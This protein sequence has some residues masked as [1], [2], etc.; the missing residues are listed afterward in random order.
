MPVLQ[1][2]RGCAAVAG[3]LANL[4]TASGHPLKEADTCVVKFLDGDGAL[5]GDM[6]DLPDPFV[7]EEHLPALLEGLD[8]EADAGFVEPPAAHTWLPDLASAHVGQPYN[9]ND[10]Q[11]R[12]RHAYARC[13]MC[14]RA[15]GCWCAAPPTVPRP[16][17]LC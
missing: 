12:P 9:T 2:F 1:R 13:F 14:R 8:P 17:R 15:D 10:F 4:V 16:N 7:I 5:P 11:V 3:E 6:Q